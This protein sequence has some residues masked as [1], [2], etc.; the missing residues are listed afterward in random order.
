MT[1]DVT[2]VLIAG[3]CIFASGGAAT[4]ALL[5]D[6][7]GSNTLLRPRFRRRGVD[8]AADLAQD[9]PMQNNIVQE[10]SNNWTCDICAR[11]RPTTEMVVLRR[12]DPAMGPGT[13]FFYCADGDCAPKLTTTGAPVAPAFERNTGVAWIPERAPSPGTANF[14]AGSPHEWKNVEL[15]AAS[16]VDPC[17]TMQFATREECEACCAAFEDITQNPWRPTEHVFCAHVPAVA[18]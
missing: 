3:L 11:Q 15:G 4:L 18:K 12:D 13:P 6:G 2:S 17:E 14:K 16:T 8:S 5:G 7:T 9:Q 1:I 10:I